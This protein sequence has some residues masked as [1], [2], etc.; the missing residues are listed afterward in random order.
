MCYKKMKVSF[1]FTFIITSKTGIE[2]QAT[3]LITMTSWTK[4]SFQKYSSNSNKM[5]I[6]GIVWVKIEWWI[7]K[8]ILIR[9]W[10]RVWRYQWIKVTFHRGREYFTS[11]KIRTISIFSRWIMSRGRIMKSKIRRKLIILRSWI[12]N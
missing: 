8:T 3:K 6:M 2:W 9:C 5:K 4:V 1:G 12:K 10:R 11:S 7:I